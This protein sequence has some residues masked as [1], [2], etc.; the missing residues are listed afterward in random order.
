MSNPW[1]RK[2]VISDELFFHVGNYD[3]ALNLVKKYHYSKRMASNVQMVGTWHK[4]GGLFGEHGEAIAAIVF[5]IPPTRWSEDVWELSRLVRRDDAE[6]SLSALM[7]KALSFMKRAR[8]IDL[9]VSFADATQGHHGGIYQACSWNYS[10][11]RERCIDGVI[12][13]GNFIPGRSAN[14]KWGTRSPGKLRRMGINA[15][16]HY[17][18][19][20]YLYWKALNRNG[21]K[22]ARRLGLSEMPYPKPFGH[23]FSAPVQEGF[24]L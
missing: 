21:A 12:F 10:G 13:E 5:S 15:I 8:P 24:D 7:A 3:D 11:K 2:D 16:P 20:K 6:I 14:S 18:E 1:K 23:K 4:G 9:L 22:K 17:D 19:G